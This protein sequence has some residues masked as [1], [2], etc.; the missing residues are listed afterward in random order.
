M[1]NSTSIDDKLI[2][3]SYDLDRYIYFDLKT[4]KCQD[5]VSFSDTAKPFCNYLIKKEDNIAVRFYGGKTS[6]DITDSLIYLPDTTML[7]K[8]FKRIKYFIS[9]PTGI[10]EYVN[11]LDCTSK[12]NI[13]TI[14]KTLDELYPNCQVVRHEIKA[15]PNS[16]MKVMFEYVMLNTKLNSHELKVFKKWRQNAKETKLPLLTFSE[17]FHKCNRYLISLQK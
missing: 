12:R 11:Y 2:K 7:N 6:V 13:F 1:V 8:S 3:Q 14:N 16:E 5:Y 15:D 9:R 4:M 10:I 17:A